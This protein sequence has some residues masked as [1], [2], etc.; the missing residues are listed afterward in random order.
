MLGNIG[1]RPAFLGHLF[2]RFDLEFFRV[3]LATHGTSYLSLIMRLEGIYETRGD[4]VPE[5][6]TS[7]VAET[8]Y[9]FQ[10]TG[11]LNVIPNLQ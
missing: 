9:G 3:K 6:N 4:S 5:Q 1:D 8:N 2:D 11:W 7:Y 10:V